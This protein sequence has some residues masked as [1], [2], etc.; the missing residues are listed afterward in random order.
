VTVVDA[1]VAV[2]GLLGDRTA[3]AVLGGPGI[4]APELIDLEIASV[5]RKRTA[6]GSLDPD[7][8]RAALDAWAAWPVERYRHAPLVGRAWELRHDVTPYDA[9]YVALAAL[10][11]V[12]LVTADAKLAAAPGHR[13]TVRV[14]K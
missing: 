1:S 12:D 13:A 7:L 5:L 2:A 9:A 3:A 11:A 6:S 8:A 14:V 4:S 10:L